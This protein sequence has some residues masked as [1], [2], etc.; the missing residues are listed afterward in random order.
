MGPRRTGSS[1]LADTELII[2]D[3]LFDCYVPLRALFAENYAE[4]FNT[5]YTHTWSRREVDTCL[6]RLVQDGLLVT[7]ESAANPVF[8][9]TRT[10]GALWEAERSPDWNLYCAVS[11]DWDD[12]LVTLSVYA[13]SPEV[14]EEY[15]RLAKDC[16]IY[17]DVRI[18]DTMWTQPAKSRIYWKDE[19]R[20]W[21]AVLR[22]REGEADPIE[23][24]RFR[25]NL[26]SWSNINDLNV[27]LKR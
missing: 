17:S 26:K 20:P 3:P 15:L 27:L 22:V 10:G 4:A 16:R 11:E 23:V 25:K 18:N 21:C 9:L 13:F 6:G 24:T 7:R 19:P 2:I 14:G 5:P 1:A 12:T 8:G